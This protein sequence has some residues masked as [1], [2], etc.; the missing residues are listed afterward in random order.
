MA[1][2]S[3]ES[4]SAAIA[5]QH[6]RSSLAEQNIEFENAVQNA[7]FVRRIQVTDEIPPGQE[8]IERRR[9]DIEDRSARSAR[10]SDEQTAKPAV[11][12]SSDPMVFSSTVALD[13]K[14]KPA[15]DGDLI[16]PDGYYTRFKTIV[17]V[18]E[19]TFV[20]ANLRHFTPYQI[21]VI[22]CRSG[23][24][25]NKCGPD[26]VVQAR[27]LK[28]PGADRITGLQVHGLSG[29]NYTADSVQLQWPTPQLVN[30]MVVTYTIRY[31]RMNLENSQYT[32]LCLSHTSVQNNNTA[33]FLLKHLENGNYSFTVMATSL[34]GAGQFSDPVYYYVNV[35]IPSRISAIY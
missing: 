26:R 12:G 8:I 30:G 3:T 5:P 4:G 18:S 11:A 1:E 15:F 7:V 22:A 16:G 21:T 19:T 10:I 34:S 29:A 32:D 31:Q 14:L 9:R 23:P 35:S 6:S 20:V 13:Q 27:T 24:G 25:K 28:L 17:D 33:Q 2:S